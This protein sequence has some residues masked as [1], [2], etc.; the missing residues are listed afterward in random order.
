M[1]PLFRD[2]P[3]S[4]RW[5]NQDDLIV[6]TLPLPDGKVFLYDVDAPR[7]PVPELAQKLRERFPSGFLFKG[8][9]LSTLEQ[10]GISKHARTSIGGAAKILLSEYKSPKKVRN[11]C[12]RVRADLT[13]KEAPLSAALAENVTQIKAR[14][15]KDESEVQLFY[16]S[17]PLNADRAFG[18]FAS[19]NTLSALVTL[20]RYGEKSWHTEL[21]LRDV[22]APAGA[23]E[24]LVDEVCKILLSECAEALNLGEVPLIFSK[25]SLLKTSSFL[26]RLVIKQAELV[27]Q[28]VQSLYNIDGLYQFKN[29]FEPIWEAT[30]F[31]GWPSLRAHDLMAI[32]AAANLF[33][34][35]S[36]PTVQN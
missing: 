20:T 12:N 13:V 18:A 6:Q 36:P 3:L 15:F 26:Q 24:L 2:L 10:F 5:S 14:V 8:S 21:L 32:A 30:Y 25:L 35:A 7:M 11:F 9:N 34:L 28:Q 4:W 29:K 22:A 33:S 16:R 31:C 23:M 27:K 17:H 1:D 19:D